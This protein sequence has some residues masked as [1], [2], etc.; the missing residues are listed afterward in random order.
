MFNIKQPPLFVLL[1]EVHS[2]Q[3][4]ATIHV[5][6]P[7]YVRRNIHLH[8]AYDSWQSPPWIRY[9]CDSEGVGRK[10]G[11]N[12]KWGKEKNMQGYTF[13]PPLLCLR[14]LYLMPPPR[15]PHLAKLVFYTLNCK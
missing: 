3:H 13:F 6:Q 12:R 8:Y 4:T 14:A 15:A 9:V 2:L 11:L 5:T 7:T 10:A 1:R